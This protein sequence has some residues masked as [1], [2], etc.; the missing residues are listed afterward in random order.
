MVDINFNLDAFKA[1]FGDGARSNLFYFIPN[2]PASIDEGLGDRTRFLV[3]STSLPDTTI[4]EVAVDWQGYNFKFA[5]KHTY[6]DF[7]VVFSVDRK[8]KIRLA[9]ENWVNK[10]IHNPLTNEY[11]TSDSYMRDQKLQWLGYD[12]E[13]IMEYTLFNAWPSKLG[14]IALDYSTGAIS[15]FDVAFAYSHFTSKNSGTGN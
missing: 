10:K 9:F 6:S 8:A 7:T 3:K 4:E 15:T 11:F 1:G 5:G 2:F 13:V 12:G 14:A